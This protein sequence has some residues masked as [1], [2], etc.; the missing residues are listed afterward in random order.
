MPDPCQVVR[1]GIVIIR[2][3]E[4][5]Q[6]QQEQAENRPCS[7]QDLLTDAQPFYCCDPF[8]ER[9]L[10]VSAKLLPIASH[11]IRKQLPSK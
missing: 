8:P 4:Q 6:K 7:N 10:Q 11:A 2:Y 1:H 9:C 5:C 3:G